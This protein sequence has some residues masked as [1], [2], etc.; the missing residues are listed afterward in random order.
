VALL[1]QRRNAGI[2][3]FFVFVQ[4]GDETCLSFMRSVV[5]ALVS[6]VDAPSTAVECH[7]IFLSREIS[8]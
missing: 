8:I 6:D 7:S 2:E 1:S 5:V 4:W 3:Q